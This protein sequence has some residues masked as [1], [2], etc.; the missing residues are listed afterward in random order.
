MILSPD[1]FHPSRTPE[2]VRCRI[3]KMSEFF[4]SIGWIPCTAGHVGSRKRNFH[5]KILAGLHKI[6]SYDQLVIFQHSFLYLR[7]EFTSNIEPKVAL[8]GQNLSAVPKLVPWLFQSLFFCVSYFYLS[9]IL[10]RKNDLIIGQA[11]LCSK[12][13]ANLA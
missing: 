3:P 1:R 12:C 8:L 11:F 2:N 4:L 7:Q 10:R 13:P 9:E 5:Q 6:Y